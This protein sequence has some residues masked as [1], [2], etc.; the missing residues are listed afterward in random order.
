MSCRGFG[1]Y[2]F[3]GVGGDLVIPTPHVNE[4]E[5]SADDEL[6]L[7]V[8]DGITDVMRDDSMMEVAINA[9]SKVESVALLM[10]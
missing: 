7:L 2:G 10:A 9:I 4:L 1:D 5:L 6:L 3:K 8:S